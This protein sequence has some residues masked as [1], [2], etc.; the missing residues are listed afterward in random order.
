ME[1]SKEEFTVFIH[2]AANDPNSDA[3]HELYQ[4]LVN[5]FT[6]AD[7]HKQ[8]RVMVSR[9]AK[10]RKIRAAGTKKNR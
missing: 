4:L 6:R 3:R 8:G 7:V 5:V 2:Q 10:K 1:K 9:K